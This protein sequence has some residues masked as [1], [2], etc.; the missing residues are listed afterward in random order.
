MALTLLKPSDQT[1]YSAHRPILFGLNQPWYVQGYQTANDDGFGNT[2]FRLSGLVIYPFPDFTKK[3]WV[4]AGPYA[5]F[6]NVLS[7]DSVNGDIYTDTPYNGA[8]PSFPA[9][10]RLFYCVVPFGYRV[11]Y[12][13]PLQN[14]FIDIRAYHKFDGTAYVNIG[15]MLKNVFPGH[16]APIIGFDENMYTWFRVDIIPLDET[17]DFLNTYS[18]SIALFTGWIYTTELYYCLNAAVQ[19]GVLQNLVAAD[20]FIAEASPIFFADCCNV[21][22]KIITNRAYNLLACPDGSPFGIGAMIIEDTNIVG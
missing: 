19:H 18:L 11:W 12:G 3:F 21:F 4:E 22:T 15:E 17:I 2:V 8:D 6:H 16:P 14:K 20:K 1:W 7:F 10:Q 13:Y 5:G 9:L